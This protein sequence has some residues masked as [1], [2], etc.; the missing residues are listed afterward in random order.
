[1]PNAVKTT[2]LALPAAV[3]AVFVARYGIALPYW[4]QWE[5]VPLLDKVYG[6]TATFADFFA[7]HNAHRILFPRGIMIG[8]ARLTAWDIRAELAV[9]VALGLALFAAWLFLLQTNLRRDVGF[10]RFPWALAGSITIFSMAQWRNWLW[11]WQLQIFL[12]VAMALW[13]VALLAWRPRGWGLAAALAAAVIGTFSFAAGL[14]IWPAGAVVLLAAAPEGK[15]AKGPLALWCIAAFAAAG[16]Y[17]YGFTTPADAKAPASILDSIL[18]VLAF[19]G[20]GA[21][22]AHAPVAAG[23][24]LFGLTMAAICLVR[25]LRHP[26]ARAK[27]A[28]FAAIALFVLASAIIA[29]MGRAGEGMAQAVESRYATFAGPFWLAL[30]VL[31]DMAD[32]RRYTLGAW[33]RP[34]PFNVLGIPILTLILVLAIAANSLHGAYAGSQRGV[35]YNSLRPALLAATY[36][37]TLRRLYPDPAAL[38]QRAAILQRL[39]LT[40]YREAPP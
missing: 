6:G 9:N 38:R 13:A 7:L 34:T 10:S 25:L 28:P 31:L 27:A 22:N 15:P 35:Y 24:G 18:Y 40:V 2:L 5:L 21:W 32:R 11:G 3:L 1:M 39:R 37:E 17:L 29:A 8:L 12:C 19:I 26:A 23:L 14:A 36:D 30:V 4:D 20:G 33:H 16:A